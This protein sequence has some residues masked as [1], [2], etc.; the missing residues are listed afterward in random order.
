MLEIAR[1]EFETYPSWGA[2][3]QP[4]GKAPISADQHRLYA[5]NGGSPASDGF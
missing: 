2:K 5:L 1:K 3:C 4:G